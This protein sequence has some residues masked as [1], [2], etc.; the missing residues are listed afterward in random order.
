MHFVQF[1]FKHFNCRNE[2]LWSWWYSTNCEQRIIWLWSMHAIKSN[3]THEC[4]T[5]YMLRC[6][7]KRYDSIWTLHPCRYIYCYSMRVGTYISCH[8]VCHLQQ[9]DYSTSPQCSPFD[10]HLL[11]WYSYEFEIQLLHTC[12]LS[13]LY[14]T[15]YICIVHLHATHSRVQLCSIYTLWEL[16]IYKH[17]GTRFKYEHT[18]LQIVILL[19]ISGWYH[20]KIVA[21]KVK[22][23]H[24]CKCSAY[25]HYPLLVFWFYHHW[26]VKKTTSKVSLYPKTCTMSG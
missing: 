10:R 21:T 26:S 14:V 12:T 22:L 6:Q 19:L 3:C 7:R 24:I 4:D 16:S 20:L 11:Q 18:Q 2:K 15:N 1:I 23:T 8:L 13:L 5:L 9:V 25:K 17:C